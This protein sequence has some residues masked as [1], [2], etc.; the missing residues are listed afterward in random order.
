[1]S[2]SDADIAGALEL[3]SDIEDV[4]TRKMMGG[5][6]LYA[7]GTIFAML[8]S[9]GQIL[10]KAQGE[11]IDILED[12]GATHWTYVRKNGKAGTMPYWT[13]PDAALDDPDLACSLARRSLAILEG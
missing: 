6:C 13:L 7:R 10:L 9:D 11:M 4:S 8:R 1:M 5:L 3:F 2:V 12:H